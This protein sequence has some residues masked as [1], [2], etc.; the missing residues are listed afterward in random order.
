M[1]YLPMDEKQEVNAMFYLM[2]FIFIGA[3]SG[4][5]T[6]EAVHAGIRPLLMEWLYG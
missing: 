3:D 1:I 5:Y 2:A 6:L 4:D